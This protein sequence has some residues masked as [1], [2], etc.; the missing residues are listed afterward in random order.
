MI[1]KDHHNERI[2]PILLENFAHGPNAVDVLQ[3]KGLCRRRRW[4]TTRVKIPMGVFVI[5][6][7]S[8]NELTLDG[9]SNSK[10]VILSTELSYR[11]YINVSGLAPDRGLRAGGG[12]ILVR[13]ICDEAE[14][15]LSYRQNS[16]NAGDIPNILI[17]RISKRS[18]DFGSMN[19]HSYTS[20][21]ATLNKEIS[22]QFCDSEI[23]G[24]FNQ[25]LMRPGA[26]YGIEGLRIS[27]PV[28]L[29]KE[30]IQYRAIFGPKWQS[31]WKFGN[32]YCGSREINLPINGFT[33]QLSDR[34]KVLYTLSYSGLFANGVVIG[35]VGVGEVCASPD[36][37]ILVGMRISIHKTNFDG[38]DL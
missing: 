4:I 1:D 29:D 30:D 21:S 8:K 22:L 14:I 34:A 17:R 5:E 31:P 15:L 28:E 16:N 12:G 11:D 2:E 19:N 27:M 9:S 23:K 18:E 7:A 20:L 13:N 6:N 35:P 33:I 24:T 3:A 10:D 25:W 37:Q 38:D 26:P 32:E 36:F